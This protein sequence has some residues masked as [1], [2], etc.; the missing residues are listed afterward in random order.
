MGTHYTSA[1]MLSIAVIAQR[2]KLQLS[3]SDVAQ[4][5]G[6]RQQT[7]SA[8]ENHPENTKLDTLFRILSAVE[9][10]IATLSKHKTS[11]WKQEW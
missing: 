10:D 7:V 11:E 8:F 5:V 3:Q 4:K 2:K 6:L 1:K 9:L